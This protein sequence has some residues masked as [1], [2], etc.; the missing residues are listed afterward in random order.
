VL[1]GPVLAW[2]L[3]PDPQARGCGPSLARLARRA[4]VATSCTVIFGECKLT[5]CILPLPPCK[6][7]CGWGKRWLKAHAHGQDKRI[8]LVHGLD[9]CLAAFPA[10]GGVTSVTVI[11][12]HRS[13][14]EFVTPPRMRLRSPSLK[15][16]ECSMCWMSS[17]TPSLATPETSLTSL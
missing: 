12:T 16:A 15:L 6:N 4:C 17:A 8:I 11:S 13:F 3:K 2:E 9:G 1:G 7:S 14:P 5:E 10:P